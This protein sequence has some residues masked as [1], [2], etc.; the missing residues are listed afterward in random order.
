MARAYQVAYHKYH[1]NDDR[2]LRVW[3]TVYHSFE[4]ATE[5]AREMQANDYYK[6]VKIIP[7]KWTLRRVLAQ[8]LEYAKY[9]EIEVVK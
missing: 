9:F 8:P 5:K 6:N 2:D 7:W 4:S 3:N 1:D